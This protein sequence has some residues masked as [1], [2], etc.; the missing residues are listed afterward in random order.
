DESGT[1]HRLWTTSRGVEDL[2]E[3]L[4]DRRLMIADG[5]HRYAV[6]LAYREEMRAREGPGSWDSMMML[7]VDGV[8]EDPPVLP[9]HRVVSEPGD[10][11]PEPD[12]R[13]SHPAQPGGSR[14]LE[15]GERVR[16]LAE[17]LA[18]LRDE[19]LTYGTVRME[20]GE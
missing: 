20:D 17:I 4:R 13:L 5:H 10:I 2:A 19:D 15:D 16:D 12:N 3:A 18:T 7:I 6:A 1:T 8:T 14:T 11:L 9:I